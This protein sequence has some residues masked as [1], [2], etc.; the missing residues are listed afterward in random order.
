MAF[1]KVMEYREKLLEKL[2]KDDE[3]TTF[4]SLKRIKKLKCKYNVIFGE[5]SSG[6]TYA[7]LVE[8]LTMYIKNGKQFAYLRRWEEDFKGKRGAQLFNAISENGVISE[9]TNGEYNTVY[10]YSGRF[11]LSRYDKEKCSRINDPNPIGFCFAI[12]TMEHDKSTSYPNVTTIIFDEFLT[13]STYIVDEFVE[14]CNVLSTIIRDRD[15]ATIYMLGNTVNKYC[16][17]FKEMGLKNVKNMK[18]GDIDIYTYGNTE[19]KVAVE[20]TGGGRIRTSKKSD[21]YFAFNNPKLNMITSGDW[22]L[23]IYPHCPMKYR[24]MDVRY[25]YFIEF[26]GETLQA[27]IVKKDSVIFTYIHRKTTPIKDEDRD[28]IFTTRHDPRRNWKRNITRPTDEFSKFVWKQFQMQKVYFQD[29]E[30]GDIVMNYV[31]WCDQ[32]KAV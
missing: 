4:Y 13:R 28:I 12:S 6:K 10:Y 2:G 5:R 29:N 31:N 14:F 7:C 19:L 30:V 22:E 18:P 21:A 26:D 1:D 17:Y 3:T 9:L 27:E 16:P 25:N 32:L 20:Y 24:P 15:D 11:Y 23:D 8:A